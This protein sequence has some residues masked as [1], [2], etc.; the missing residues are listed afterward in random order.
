MVNYS[1]LHEKI[2][3][4]GTNARE[5]FDDY[6]CARLSIKI[7]YAVFLTI[8]YFCPLGFSFKDRTSL[9]GGLVPRT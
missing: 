3:F 8:R 9:P 2:S 7:L 1:Q 5:S 6:L 4:S